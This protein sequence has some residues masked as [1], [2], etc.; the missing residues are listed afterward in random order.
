MGPLKDDTK[1]QVDDNNY[2]NWKNWKIL[3]ILKMFGIINFK[4]I[5]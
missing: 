3:K 2:K 5:L 4:T 1:L